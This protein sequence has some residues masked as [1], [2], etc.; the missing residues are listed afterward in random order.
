MLPSA[1]KFKELQPANTQ[2]LVE[3]ETIE[4]PR[5]LDTSKWVVNS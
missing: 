5:R 2:D 1:R 4:M 3:M